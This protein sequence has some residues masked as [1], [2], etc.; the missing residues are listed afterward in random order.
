MNNDEQVIKTKLS[1]ITSDLNNNN[2]ISLPLI[3]LSKVLSAKYVYCGKLSD[4]RKRVECVCFVV[5]GEIAGDVSYAVQEAPC[6][7]ALE[8]NYYSIPSGIAASYPVFGHFAHDAQSYA[9][10]ILFSRTG[11]PLGVL[12]AMDV[13]PFD[14]DHLVAD[15]FLLAVPGI[16]TELQK[17]VVKIQNFDLKKREEILR[18]AIEASNLGI[19]D[20]DIASGEM[21]WSEY[22]R[23]LLDLE[24]ESLN[25]AHFL[26]KIHP[27]HRDEVEIKIKKALD[28]GGIGK[29]QVDY[30]IVD[31]KSGQKKWIRSVSKTIFDSD[32]NPVR[33]IGT[34]RDI[35]PHI[36][37]QL[38]LEQKT[39]ELEFLNEDLKNFSFTISHDI[40][41]PLS[42]LLLVTSISKNFTTIAEYQEIMP[43]IERNGNRINEILKNV[44][45]IIREEET[46]GKIE[47]L[48][49]QNIIGEV[50]K[51]LS[52]QIAE[53]NSEIVTDLELKEIRFIKSYL[54]SI[55]RNLLDNAIKYRSP[56]RK[57][58]INISMKASG[59]NVKIEMKDNGTGIDLEK[60]QRHLFQPFKRFTDSQPGTGIGLFMIKRMIEKHRGTIRLESEFGKGTTFYITLPYL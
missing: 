9:G 40:K 27:D 48:E 38:A 18:M 42:S 53:S 43:L 46:E 49:T 30:V 19:C 60:Y 34:V 28:P 7:H 24:S 1:K 59:E 21:I 25:L 26:Q 14:D 56:D 50:V 52:T 11:S 31:G 33:L 47:T 4:D 17:T 39:R 44:L 8:K 35:T 58:V 32:R 15:V 3:H 5:N 41:N 29:C 10:K 20:F 36:E 16:E 2:P 37:N 23:K 54:Q 22:A 57:P 51:E 55:L 45:K 12:W 6:Q 13:K